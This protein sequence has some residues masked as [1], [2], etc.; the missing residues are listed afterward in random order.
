MNH[1]RAADGKRPVRDIPVN[2]TFPSSSSLLLLLPGFQT[3]N[4]YHETEYRTSNK[5]SI[6]INYAI[7]YVANV[8]FHNFC[9]LYNQKGKKMNSED[10]LLLSWRQEEFKFLHLLGFLPFCA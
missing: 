3:Q 1:T 6:I 5:E 4:A 7:N 9:F 10:F 2:I 8:S